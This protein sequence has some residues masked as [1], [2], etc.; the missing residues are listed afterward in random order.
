V[1][2]AL[3]LLAALLL[4]A[5]AGAAGI[6]THASVDIVTGTE[7]APAPGAG[8]DFALDGEPGAGLQVTLEVRDLRGEVIARRSADV[9]L[10]GTGQAV[11]SFAPAA[12]LQPRQ[13][14]LLVIHE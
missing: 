4:S 10:D 7:I 2:P 5:A 11:A 3:F 13:V 6:A 14:T 12:T 8:L 1:R 9:A